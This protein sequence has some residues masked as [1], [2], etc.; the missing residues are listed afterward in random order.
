MASK[1]YQAAKKAGVLEM[2]FGTM[3]R[4]LRPDEDISDGIVCKDMFSGLTVEEHIMAG[5]RNSSW[6]STTARVSVGFDWAMRSGCRLCVIDARKVF[7]TCECVDAREGLNLKGRHKERAKSSQEI[8]VKN[9]IPA[10]AIICVLSP[11]EILEYTCKNCYS[12]S[13]MRSFERELKS[14]CSSFQKGQIINGIRSLEAWACEPKNWAEKKD[15]IVMM[16]QK[17]YTTNRVLDNPLQL[18]F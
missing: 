2:E 6:I 11:E 15:I 7:V 5:A 17:L 4:V 16:A 14:H 1:N 10:E 13:E 9:R 3:F 18:E 8:C 12:S